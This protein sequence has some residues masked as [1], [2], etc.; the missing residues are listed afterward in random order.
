MRSLNKKMLAGILSPIWALCGAVLAYDVRGRPPLLLFILGWFGLW[1]GVALFLA[2]LG[3]KSRN[4][5]GIIPAALTILC[6]IALTWVILKPGG[7]SD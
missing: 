1:W 2:V 3:L 4:L 7:L 5:A 6:F